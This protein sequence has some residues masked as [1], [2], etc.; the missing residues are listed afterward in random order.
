MYISF[1]VWFDT[2]NKMLL[3]GFWYRCLDLAIYTDLFTLKG[4]LW[5]RTLRCFP[6]LLFKRDISYYAFC[7]VFLHFFSNEVSTHTALFSITTS[8]MK[9]LPTLTL[10]FKFST[11]KLKYLTTLTTLIY[12]TTIILNLLKTHYFKINYNWYI[13]LHHEFF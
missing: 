9:S 7:T 8:K 6:S 11:I 5:L 3:S 2:C 4:Y 12:F 10:L 1:K 13:K